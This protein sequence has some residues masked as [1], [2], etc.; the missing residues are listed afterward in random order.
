[1][2]SE[3]FHY[4]GLLKRIK[5]KLKTCHVCQL[6]KVSTQSS[7]SP[8]QPIILSQ[9]L[10]AVFIDFYGP[11]PTAKYG[12]KYILATLDGFSKYVK[13]Y[14]L[15]RQTTSATIDKI[16]GHYIPLLGKPSRIVTDHGTQFTTQVWKDKL[17]KEGIKHTLTSIRHP[18]ANIVERVNRELSKVFRIL[19]GEFKHS[20]WYDK[21]QT[22]EDILNETH[23]DTTEFTPMEIMLKKK[24]T[25]FWR[26][27][28][29]DQR[30][31]QQPTD[32]QKLFWV[33]E[34][35]KKKGTMRAQKTDTGRKMTSYQENEQVLVKAY[36]LSDKTL[37]RTAKFM[38]VFE[39]P[40]I[41]NRILREGTYLVT[42][43]TN[44]KER[45]VFHANDLRRYYAHHSTL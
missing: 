13:L 3:G 15:R 31:D 10:E 36:N 44:N 33:R 18:Q 37:K 39:G 6:N 32:E 5:K 30:A 28:L 35:I 12:F 7:F 23:H 1:M 34:R 40:Y 24:P 14:P 9:P 38:S 19:L 43:A 11:L 20:S 45:G 42:D 26:K 29:P 4:P 17:R 2:L 27:W 41:I 8:S 25:R 16:F 22:I 21:M